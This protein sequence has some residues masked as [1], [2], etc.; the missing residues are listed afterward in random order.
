MMA[1]HAPE[2]HAKAVLKAATKLG[3]TADA[4]AADLAKLTLVPP[5]APAGLPI[6][7]PA[8]LNK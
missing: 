1:D 3:A 4:H 5:S 8:S 2:I 7:P 6:A